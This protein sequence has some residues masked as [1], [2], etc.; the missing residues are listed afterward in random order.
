MN[1]CR[2]V[3]RFVRI[4]GVE[5]TCIPESDPCVHLAAFVAEQTASC[6]A[7]C[8]SPHVRSNIFSTGV[9]PIDT[10]RPDYE[11]RAAGSRLW[12]WTQIKPNTT[13]SPVQCGSWALS[14]RDADAIGDGWQYES[15]ACLRAQV[16]M[17]FQWL[18]VDMER[19]GSSRRR[20]EKK[21]HS[22]EDAKS[23]KQPAK[24]QRQ[25]T[26]DAPLPVSPRS[27]DILQRA[28]GLNGVR[29]G[30][31]GGAAMEEA[32]GHKRADTAPN[33]VGKQSEDSNGHHNHGHSRNFTVGN[34]GAGGT[35]YLKPTR[36][37]PNFT[38]AP[39][40]PPATS[41]GSASMYSQGP[42]SRE[43]NASG[44]WTPRVARGR[45]A[46]MGR[47]MGA[48]PLSLANNTNRPLATRS[49]SCSTVDDHLRATLYDANEFN[50]PQ[51]HDEIPTRRRRS[52]SA[53]ELPRHELDVHIPHYRLGMPRFSDRGTAYLHYSVATNSTVAS[54]VL[55][56]AEYDKLF[57]IPPGRGISFYSHLSHADVPP[58]QRASANYSPSGTPYT[59]TPVASARPSIV[60]AITPELFYALEA[61]LHDSSVVHYHPTSGRIVAATPAR[62]IAQITSPQFLDYELLADF[63]L[64]FRCFMSSQDVLE[65]LF[66]RMRWA[67]LG[68]TDGGR[69]A[70]V[71][72]FV[73]IRHWILN[74]FQ[75]DFFPDALFR[76]S[77]CDLVNHLA[78][79][80][81][82]RPDKGGGDI[83]IIGE[84]KKC[85][86]RTCALYWP[87]HPD[88]HV[89]SPDKDVSA[90]GV[91]DLSVPAA[92]SALSLPLSFRR[93]TA[94]ASI[95]E[96]EQIQLPEEPKQVNWGHL[97][98]VES[99]EPSARS[100]IATRT[101][102]LPVSA[103]SSQSLEVLSCSIPFLFRNLRP[104]ARSRAKPP[105][106][107]RHVE[108][109]EDKGD[110]A[111]TNKKPKRPSHGHKRSGSFSDA[112]RDHRTP[113]S[114]PR[115]D[116]IELKDLPSYAVTG[117]LVR[118]LV[119]T[120]ASAKV[121]NNIPVTPGPPGPDLTEARLQG[122][123]KGYFEQGQ[124]L[125]VKKFVGEVKRALSSRKAS[126]ESPARS[127]GSSGGSRSTVRG[128][129][130]V[131]TKPQPDWQ[132]LP[133]PDRLDV[134]GLTVE[135]TFQDS[136]DAAYQE[137]AERERALTEDKLSEKSHEGFRTPTLPD[138]DDQIMD[139][140]ATQEK[141][142]REKTL[143]QTPRADIAETP[144]PATA[145]KDTTES[146]KKRAE[147]VEVMDFG[148]YNSQIN[149]QVTTRSR[150]IV[151]V[152]ATG[153]P[154]I[155]IMSGGLGHSFSSTSTDMMPIPLFR[156]KHDRPPVPSMPHHFAKDYAGVGA[157][158]AAAS[159]AYESR[160]AS[161][162]VDG[163]TSD[164]RMHDLLTAPNA[165]DVD[166]GSKACS[167]KSEQAK[168][169]DRSSAF[170][171][172]QFQTSH[173]PQ[174]LRR[175][176]GGD[177][178]NAHHV[179]SL[180]MSP[181]RHSA[182]TNSTASRSYA[183]SRWLS[184]TSDGSI[185]P[186]DLPPEIRR[187]V[188]LLDTPSSAQILRASFE[189]EA[190][191]LKGI[192]DD[193]NSEG[194]I[195]DALLK[196]E[197]K[198]PSPAMSANRS[199]A[200]FSEKRPTPAKNAAD[201]DY[202]SEK[203]ETPMVVETPERYSTP[204]A[205][206][207]S[208]DSA[209]EEGTPIKY[210][211]LKPTP[212]QSHSSSSSLQSH[213][214]ASPL[215]SHPYV[216]LLHS[217][218]VASSL[219][220]HPLAPPPILREMPSGDVKMTYVPY[221]G[222]ESSP[223]NTSGNSPTITETQ[224]ASIYHLSESGMQSM[225]SNTEY[226]L[227][228]F[229]AEWPSAAFASSTS[230]LPAEPCLSRCP[231]PDP[232]HRTATPESFPYE[233]KPESIAQSLSD[234]RYPS[235]RPGPWNAGGEHTSFPLDDTQTLSDIS[236]EIA[237]SEMEDSGVRSFYYDDDEPIPHI[238]PFAPPT[239]PSTNGGT[240]ESPDKRHLLPRLLPRDPERPLKETIG[241]PRLV[242]Q[243]ANQPFPRR[244]PGQNGALMAHH[245]SFAETP[246][247]P[248][249][250]PFVLA[251]ESEVIAEQL[252]II[253]KDALDEVDWKDLVSLNWQQSAPY[254]RNWVDYV[255]ND[256]SLEANG[257]D[258]VIARFNLVVKW[259]ISEIVLTDVPSER[260]RT[261]T[262]YIH[263]ASHCHRLHNFASLYQITLALLSPELA[264][265]SRTWSL[266]ALREKQMLEHLEQLCRPLRNFYTLRAEMETAMPQN[267]IIPFIGLYT[268][269]LMFNALKSARIDA[270]A[271]GKEP[272]VNFERYQTA[273]TIVK[274]LLRLIEASSMYHFRPEP[275][276]L[277]RCLWIAA[278]EDDDIARRSKSLEQI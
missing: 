34:V 167:Q 80:L 166:Y 109:K 25:K 276:A 99:N 270:P 129:V 264:R 187:S 121:D 172:T 9:P 39:A 112:L 141:Y 231:I 27:E 4:G 175:V 65:F 7:R 11:Q 238:R 126:S 98:Q 173:L 51:D 72:T 64:T 59:R 275:E 104:T 120:P 239:P 212:L 63:F 216:S 153:A 145:R 235:F 103:T 48:P 257:I 57:P 124:S 94:R 92:P 111:E 221:F 90:G 155:P 152:D 205:T 208:S 194:G 40:T 203:G 131:T 266:V 54:S 16:L 61:N 252:T 87:N 38:Y 102:S 213:P 158:A 3:A 260:A 93:T 156:D 118:G 277:S 140:K 234:G 2:A 76:Q 23:T 251:Y 171:P 192:P 165:W 163:R 66:A 44:T 21:N 157:A 229:P 132:Q 273:A 74:Y 240:A 113:L 119:L 162:T 14:N 263:I 210:L 147:S 107:P 217:H 202:T 237:A 233:R 125:A 226:P 247:F 228:S 68:G 114:S 227:P 47:L 224:G 139:E 151:I 207:V 244:R 122:H 214:V 246:T 181:S 89:T 88:A 33:V 204:P 13:D 189:E 127:D 133:G 22:P 52:G 24:T 243:P 209:D 201:Q 67:F 197:G 169:R 28:F 83:N 5:G 199:S 183:R 144:R 106:A 35:L 176:P 180:E 250:M 85:W 19:R 258:I 43:S 195:E 215:Q 188:S 150:S 154:Q 206:S 174:Q 256:Q 128:R 191:R 26:T 220:S 248:A 49:H 271:A 69:I 249:H 42:L 58:F 259:C 97:A 142:H 196:L 77:F 117:G 37:P 62:L 159:S 193:I 130:R 274:N 267:G 1:Q 236:T 168:L 269:D 232:Y 137:R 164:Q 82:Q 185:V 6:A 148:R 60:G 182:D 241:P 254:V 218:P 84:L 29:G 41:D 53:A 225:S 230:V 55:S 30:V 262:K 177:L 278:L 184:L 15:Q 105:A 75:D 91:P 268:H 18:H 255:N 160:W 96:I 78:T 143:Q 242:P 135:N 31:R 46:A 116:T 261:I 198:I 86:R 200:A 170:D 149:S 50:L 179:K 136:L 79:S 81:R 123:N 211:A 134:L 108:I 56:R 17:R 100:T 223:G 70:R 265:L 10:R 253:E 45:S 138:D 146:A 71:R 32:R 20:L 272:L 36:V 95:F 219:Q 178:K 110:V 101:A 8:T 12:R 186:A 190:K 161:E 245:G 73:A 115:A 222:Q